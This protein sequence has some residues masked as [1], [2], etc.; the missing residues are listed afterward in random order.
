MLEECFTEE[1]SSFNRSYGENLT[2]AHW[3]YQPRGLVAI[4]VIQVKSTPDVSGILRCARQV[5][6]YPVFDAWNNCD[7]YRAYSNLWI[8]G[9]I[10]SY[11][12]SSV[13]K[14][15]R[16][17]KMKIHKWKIA[18]ETKNT[19]II[20]KLKIVILLTAIIWQIIAFL[21]FCFFFLFFFYFL[22]IYFHFFFHFLSVVKLSI[23]SGLVTQVKYYTMN[24]NKQ[25][26]L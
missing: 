6:A 13:S 1:C 2:I 14:L 26:P 5:I 11:Y 18:K 7:R 12:V 8:L 9:K 22:C 3:L 17:R 25:T 21:C 23:W 20:K 15:T 19:Q 10:E 16:R 24:K 4:L